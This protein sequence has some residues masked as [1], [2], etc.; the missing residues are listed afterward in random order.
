MIAKNLVTKLVGVLSLVSIPLPV[1]SQSLSLDEVQAILEDNPPATG[2][3]LL[4]DNAILNLDEYLKRPTAPIDAD[5]KAWYFSTMDSLSYELALPVP[6]GA[7]VWQMYNDGF[8]VKTP[9]TTFSF[10]LIDGYSGWF[11]KLPDEVLQQI[12]VAFISHGHGDHSGKPS[13]LVASKFKGELVLQNRIAQGTEATVGG[14]EVAAR[15][16][17]HS[18]PNNI[19]HVTTPEGITVMHTG[20]T[21]RSWDLPTDLPTDILLINA[22][23][24]ESGSR[25]ATI[26]VRNAIDRVRPA[27]TIPG[28]VQELGHVFDPT[29]VTTRVPYAWPLAVDDVPIE[30]ELSVMAW[31]EHYDYN[32]TASPVMAVSPASIYVVRDSDSDGVFDELGDSMSNTFVKTRTALG[33]VD[34]TNSNVLNRI[35]AKFALPEIEVGDPS[36]KRAV[37]RFFLED[38]DGALAGPVSLMHSTTDN[39][40]AAHVSDY[41]DLRYQDT[42]QDLINPGDT[43]Q[44]FYELDVTRLISEDYAA[45][46]DQPIA[47]FRLQIDGARFVEDDL[48]HRIRLGM[49]QAAEN[50]PELVLTF[51]PEPTG[52]APAMWGLAIISVSLARVRTVNPL[53][54]QRRPTPCWYIR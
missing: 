35:I 30:G 1:F 26:G 54:L 41:E 3:P 32:I 24:N 44:T 12:D 53:S 19:Y 33:E 8:I 47:A 39:D 16:G 18:V 40:L 48:S 15:F 14:L 6:S 9:S 52:L 23:M 17:A 51:V 4:R 13:F 27:V 20:D 50:G 21:Q 49:P 22:W 5:I 45:D 10:D 25:P 7:R 36:L 28:H 42:L 31:G 2:D 43:S 11:Y 37:L 34:S 38:A 29:D 46:G